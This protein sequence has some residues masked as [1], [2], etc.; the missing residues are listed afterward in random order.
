MLG[1]LTLAVGAVKLIEDVI[2]RESGPIDSSLL[3]FV[4]EHVPAAW[5]GFFA[6]VTL[7]GSAA[8]LVPATALAVAL[9][10]IGRRRFEAALLGA[11]AITATLLVYGLKTI[12]DRSRPAL[13]ET[14]SY[15]GSSF[16]SGHTLSTAAFATAAALCLARIWPRR[17][18]LAMAVALLWAGLVALSRLVLGVHWPSDV[19]A[20]LCLGVFIPL[21]LS[22][23][24]DGHGQRQT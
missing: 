21:L 4:H 12:V 13:W 18:N 6:M 11:S 17:A 1:V 20:A 2:D 7:S 14:Q 24:F 8:F 10:F 15:W 3:R 23:V 22:L 5:T 19:L 16:P 9:L